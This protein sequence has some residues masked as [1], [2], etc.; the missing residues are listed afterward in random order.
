MVEALGRHLCA[1]GC[2][3]QN[4]SALVY[5]LRVKRE[6]LGGAPAAD[7]VCSHRFAD[8][9][10]ERLGVS[11]D[12]SSAR[13]GDLGVRRIGFL[14]NGAGE[15]GEFIDLADQDRLAEIDISQN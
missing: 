7:A 10:L 12:R 3:G 13:V 14:N 5:G 15:A 6:S 8:I 9:G 4:E 2:L 1:A 11:A